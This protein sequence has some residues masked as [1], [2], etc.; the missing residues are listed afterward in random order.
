M[1]FPTR[2]H[3]GFHQNYVVTSNTP[4]DRSCYVHDDADGSDIARV[5]PVEAV[6]RTEPHVVSDSNTPE[7]KAQVKQ[8]WEGRGK[9]R[10]V[11]KEDIN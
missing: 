1:R 7:A 5:E 8:Y 4:A 9:L 11:R 10:P 3:G 2:A 6:S